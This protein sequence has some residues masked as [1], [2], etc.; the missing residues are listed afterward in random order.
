MTK[1]QVLEYEINTKIINNE[2]FVSLTDI[3]KKVNAEFPRFVVQNWMRN[4]DTI[5]FI[6]LWEIIYNPNFNRVEFEA[7]K[8]QYGYNRFVM[9][10]TKWI[11][12]TNAIGFITKAGKYNGGTYA[13]IDIALEFAS[14][15]SPEFKLYIYTE[16]KRL[17]TIQEKQLGWNLKRTLSKIN[18][19]IHTDAIKNNLIP[20]K[21][22]R[23]QTD[24]IYANEADVI[25]IALFGITAKEWK[26]KNISKEANIRDYANVA[27]LVCLVNLENL[28][29][30][31]INEGINQKDRL[32]KLNQIAIHQMKLLTKDIRIQELENI[33][34]VELIEN[35][36][37]S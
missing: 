13:H 17:K 2:D 27:E 35:K 14:W 1:L 16:F 34:K 5:D 10:P 4:K 22:T 30:V 20:K 3:A 25:N 28:N 15:I 36:L 37:N 26:I 6:G 18:Y 24:I 33:S 7:V 31:Y 9:S 23:N 8:L 11:E 29:S 32:I 19:N 21:V 12:N